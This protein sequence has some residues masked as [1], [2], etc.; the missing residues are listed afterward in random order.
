MAKSIR[1]K[2]NTYWDSGSVSYKRGTLSDALVGTKL[3]EET[4]NL[5]TLASQS[6]LTLTDSVYNY[7]YVEILFC[8][9]GA[10]AKSVKYIPNKMNTVILDMILFVN[11]V[12]REY[13]TTL[14]FASGTT[15]NLINK[16]FANGNGT[17]S[18]AEANLVVYKIIGYK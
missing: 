6:T 14:Q 7:S 2:N 3:F 10:Y 11:N 18:T 12:F 17:P 1:L 15:V 8:R 13:T 5:A 9:F 16:A 4:A